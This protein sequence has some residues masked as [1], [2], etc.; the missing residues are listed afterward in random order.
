[1]ARFASNPARL[2]SCFLIQSFTPSFDGGLGGG[3]PPPAIGRVP[4]L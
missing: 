4:D 3:V 1:M 2:G